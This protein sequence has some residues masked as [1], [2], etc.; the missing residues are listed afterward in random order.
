MKLNV[1]ERII[2]LNLFPD[3]GSFTNLKLIRV[4]KEK[5][6][7]S[8]EENKALS[9]QQNGEA[10]KWNDSSIKDKEFSFGEVID[11]LIVNAL[12]ELDKNEEIKNE[13]ISLYEKFITEK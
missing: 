13:H 4:A 3:K 1:L 9:F 12:K 10:L 5:L 6:S 7:F 11:K 2:L 8:E